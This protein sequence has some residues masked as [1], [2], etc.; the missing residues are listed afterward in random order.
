[1]PTLNDPANALGNYTVTASNGTLTITPASLTVRAAD[2]RRL[3]GAAN[4]PFTGELTGVVAGDAISAMYS[5]AATVTSPAGTY[6]ITPTLNDAAHRLGNYVVTSTPGTLRVDND[7]PVIATTG[8]LSPAS[9]QRGTGDLSLT[10]AGAG[11]SP[12]S[13][14]RWNGQAVATTFVSG[15]MLRATVPGASISAASTAYLSVSTGAPG[16]GTSEERAFYVVDAA[17][18]VVGTETRTS[19][20]STVEASVAG[21]TASATGSG[22]ISVAQFG[23]NP[24]GAVPFEST[25]RFFGADVQSGSSVSQVSMQFC[26]LN[27]GAVVHWWNGSSW[28]PVANQSR[29]PES[30][31]CI[32]VVA[33]GSSSPSVAQLAGIVF[34][35]GLKP[36][37]VAV[38]SW[39]APAAIQY[40]TPLS[41]TQLNASASAPGTFV[42]SPSSGAVLPV[43][44]HT[45]SVSFTPA[46]P[47]TF[48]GGS[49][50]V[51]LI[52]AKRTPTI[53]WN[54][55]DVIIPTTL[56]AAQLNAVA[57]GADGTTPLAGTYA[58]SSNGTAVTSG[59]ALPPGVNTPLTVVFTPT[60]AAANDYTTATRTVATFNVLNK[61]D[62]TPGST[63][64]AIS[65]S[66]TQKEIMVGVVSTANFDA[67][68]MV[69]SATTLGNGSGAETSVIMTN[70]VPKTGLTDLNADGR[71]DVLFYFSKAG[72]ISNGDITSSS[73][74][75]VLQGQ[76]ANGVRLKGTD[77]V[78][79][80]P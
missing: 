44:T 31:P 8:A 33:N 5:T 67:R 72:L 53:V 62:I 20:G 65:I 43:G 23:S 21:I 71:I 48:I 56:G 16:G 79:M 69:Y 60:G 19:A 26:D 22:T 2:Q 73:T 77:K 70:G 54:P 9:V 58:Y 50:S 61:I 29:V 63:S 45:L 15:T 14:I 64:N 32:T 66:G 3:F 76:L 57:Y 40:G 80:L 24:G 37:T 28:T 11:F 41:V 30:N 1:M 34:G 68:T 49:A 55:A 27:G 39:T 7:V 10:V 74:Q 47:A 4:P 12:D 25:N 13:R 78:S 17:T 36:K 46:D 75:L 52:V 42:Y 59:T 51:T 6:A 18:S 35:I 38:I